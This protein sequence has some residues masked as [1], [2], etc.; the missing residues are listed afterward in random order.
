MA[1]N[2][3]VLRERR[4]WTQDQAAAALDTTR[5][6]YAKLEGGIRRLSTP[7]ID[8]ASK[9]YG[10]D[11]SEIVRGSHVAII[12]TIDRDGR[13]RLERGGGL[14]FECPFGLRFVDGRS[15]LDG[16]VAVV[17]D[18]TGRPPRYATGRVSLLMIEVESFL[19]GRPAQSSAGP[20]IFNL[21]K[22]D[23]SS[24]T[25]VKVALSWA[26]DRIAVG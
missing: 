13:V 21:L 10:V 9:A 15:M 23:G 2:L 18:P 6:Q 14:P 26:I 11:A 12:G 22:P 3:R 4:G 24:L 7:W 25:E 19:V 20:D 1:N 17:A 8:R 5:S 16:L